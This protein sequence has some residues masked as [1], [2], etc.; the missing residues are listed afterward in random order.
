MSSMK[1]L[2]HHNG[3][4]LARPKEKV[5]IPLLLAEAQSVTFEC[6][7]F[8]E[9]KLSA[10]DRGMAGERKRSFRKSSKGNILSEKYAENERVRREKISRIQWC[11]QT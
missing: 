6:D 1:S 9:E 2:N 11:S 7:V 8:A 10:Q 5:K 3:A 4:R